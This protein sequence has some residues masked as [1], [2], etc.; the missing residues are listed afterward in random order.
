MSNNKEQLIYADTVHLFLALQRPS[1][2]GIGHKACIRHIIKGDETE[3]L[4]IFSAKISTI[5]GEWRIHRTVN[6]RD[7]NKAY[8][9]FMK[10]MIDFPERASC[11]ESVWKTSLLQVECRAEKKFML[12]VDTKS[13]KHLIE[14]SEILDKAKENIL[15]IHESPNGFHYILNPF[16][17]RELCKLQYVR[18]LRDGFFFIK[19]IKDHY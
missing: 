2:H 11:I 12:D 8:K 7:V 3:E 13:V 16:D 17:T 4:K 10:T 1:K 14:L 5:G 19:T 9:V 18:L 6:A 15:D